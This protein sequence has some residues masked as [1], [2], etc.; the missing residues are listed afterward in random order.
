MKATRSNNSEF[1]RMTPAEKES[2]IARM[3]PSFRALKKALQEEM[4]E[5]V[6]KNS[7]LSTRFGGMVC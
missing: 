6:L 2:F 5:Y 1:K 7:R 3:A 4:R